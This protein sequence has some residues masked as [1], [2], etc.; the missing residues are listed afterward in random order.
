VFD[1]NTQAESSVLLA[2]AQILGGLLFF[3]TGL[4]RL[5]LLIFA[6]SLETYPPGT[7]QLQ[8]S[9]AELVIS[10]TS[11][12]FSTGLRLVLPMIAL[13]VIIDLALALLGRLNTQLQLISLAFPVKMLA[14][15]LML[16][17]V[18]SIYPK[19]F[20]RSTEVALGTLRQVL[21][22]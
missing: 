1:P 15:L 3:A 19:L 17:W 20:A 22:L 4:D 13:L 7:F 16:A 14:T 6:R 10:L 2:T 21:T 5:V 11:N 12:I 8:R 9:M 18:V